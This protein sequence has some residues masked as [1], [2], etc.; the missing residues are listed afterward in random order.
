MRVEK[1]F[2]DAVEVQQEQ[3]A[4]TEKISV[5]KPDAWATTVESRPRQR[6]LEPWLGAAYESIR[7]LADS[8]PSMIQYTAIDKEVQSGLVLMQRITQ[9]ADDALKP[10]VQ[11]YGTDVK[12]G[13]EISEILRQA[14]FPGGNTAATPY[15]VL[16]T[17]TGL[18]TYMSNIEAHLTALVPASQAVWDGAFT[19]AVNDAK[20]CIER[21]QKWAR[22]QLAVRSAQT[23]VV[24]SSNVIK[25]GM[26]W[27]G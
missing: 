22:H 14:L 12:Y 24:P 4:S 23:L 13:K 3:S 16:L 10:M 15:G 2:S 8:Y 7:S 18:L 25:S 21:I 20:S 26:Q 19:T 17:L 6:H 11:K 1:T 9:R 5:Q 27:P